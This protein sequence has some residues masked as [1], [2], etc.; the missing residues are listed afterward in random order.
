MKITFDEEQVIDGK[1]VEQ[2]IKA[3]RLAMRYVTDLDEVEV[4]VSLVS[5]DE[6]R[7]LNRDYRG[8]DKITDVLSFPQFNDISEI[9]TMCLDGENILLGDVVMCRDKIKEQAGENGQS[10]E[11]EMIYLFIHSMLHLLGYDHENKEE[12]SA[13]RRCEKEILAKLSKCN[14][15]NYSENCA[16]INADEDRIFSIQ[17]AM[18]NQNDIDNTLSPLDIK[19]LFKHAKSALKNAYAPYSNYRVGAALMT[20]DGKIFTGCNIENASYGASIC[21]ERVA[22]VNAVSEGFA[23]FSAIAVAADNGLASMCGICRQFLSEF[24]TDILVITG[25][26]DDHLDCRALNELLPDNFKLNKK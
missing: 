3:A 13:M 5:A 20:T 10:E 4:D 15:T 24:C 26:D 8:I 9:E 22:C 14:S 17:S 2:M 1:I 12:K 11:K 16:R 19:E 18:S 6:I 25:S 7:S 23:A 21:A